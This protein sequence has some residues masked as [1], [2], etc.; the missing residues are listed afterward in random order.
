MQN[1]QCGQRVLIVLV[2]GL[3]IATACGD[4]REAQ[5]EA[6][7]HTRT[8]DSGPPNCQQ[9]LVPV[10]VQQRTSTWKQDPQT[11]KWVESWG[12]WENGGTS[13]RQATA[14]DCLKIIDAVPSAAVLPDLQIKQLDRCGRG[15]LIATGGDCF[16]IVDPAP[17]DEDFPS[18]EGRK[19]LKFPVVTF[20]VGAGP[21]EI[22][23]DRGATDVEDWTAYQTVYDRQGQALGSLYEPGIEFYY[24]GD[25]HNHWHIRDFDSYEIRDNAGTVVRTSEKH[26]YCQQDNTTYDTMAGRPGVP[27]DPVYL[28]E[29]SCGKGLPQALTIIHG[30]SRGW[31]DTYPV[32]L[33]DQDIDIT[34]LPDGT[35]NVVVRADAYD[36]ILET[37]EANNATSIQIDIV[38]DEVTIHPST[39]LGGVP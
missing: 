9:L 23:A 32:S 4:E 7:V 29:T 2:L 15:D 31:G 36:Y 5:P 10:V 8:T 28:D 6:D 11:G 16:Q 19:L 39:V 25:G 22:I 26:G 3:G 30:L 24:A 12:P 38:G 14:A 34:D 27:S 37:N 33:P 21:S 17:Y 35:Y 18:L 20:N 1:L 13:V